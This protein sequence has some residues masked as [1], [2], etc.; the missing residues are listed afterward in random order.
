MR[1]KGAGWGKWDEWFIITKTMTKYFDIPH[2]T[3][4]QFIDFDK[5]LAHAITHKPDAQE[6][7]PD[8]KKVKAD[9]KKVVKPKNKKN[10]V[11][12]VVSESDS[13]TKS[14][15]DS[16]SDSDSYYEIVKYKTKHV[17]K[18]I[19]PCQEHTTRKSELGIAVQK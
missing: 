4:I 11:K 5:F 1:A 6:V 19:G 3:I 16:D 17:K 10:I 14:D 12:K 13:D 9:L 2:G 18:V 15:S 7:K 8:I